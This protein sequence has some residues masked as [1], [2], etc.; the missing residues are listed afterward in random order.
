MTLPVRKDIEAA[1]KNDRRL[2]ERVAQIISAKRPGEAGMHTPRFDDAS[3]AQVVRLIGERARQLVPG[4]ARRVLNDWT[5]TALSAHRARTQRADAVS[6][7][8]DIA[9]DAA[10]EIGRASCRERV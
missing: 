9:P 10:Q 4:A 7:R 8:P 3:R 6:S 2:A 5:Q 1:V